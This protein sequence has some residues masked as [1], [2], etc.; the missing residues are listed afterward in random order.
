MGSLINFI[1]HMDQQL[2][3]IVNSLGGW[4]YLVLFL[5][6]F[7][8]TGLVILPFLPGDS[9]LFTAGAVVALPGALLNPWLIY[10]T[11]AAAAILG[12]SNNYFI[13]HYLGP[14]VFTGQYRWIKKEYL[15]RTQSF[16]KRHGR[17]T[18]F[19]ARFVPIVRSFAPFVAGIGNMH[20]VDFL[21]YNIF[22]GLTWTALF[23]WSGFF[24]GN[25]SVIKSHFSLFILVVIVVS[26]LPAVYEVLKER[27][28]KST[29]MG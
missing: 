4:T 17:K 2:P 25:V 22:G 28:R 15:E 8:E 29:A 26:T 9:L 6:I 7:I 12:D 24:F 3:G 5:V 18:I 11:V 16:Y 10:V 20:Y 27:R 21:R 1:L 13:G 14:K 23:F 19:L